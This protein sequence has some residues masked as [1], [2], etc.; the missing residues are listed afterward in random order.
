ML[1]LFVNNF[2]RKTMPLW[3]A[4]WNAMWLLRL[5]FSRLRSFMRFATVVADFTARTDL[6]GVTS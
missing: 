3:T 2:Q 4:W 6:S 1:Y 5:A